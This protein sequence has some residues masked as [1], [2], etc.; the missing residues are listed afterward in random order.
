MPSRR[1]PGPSWFER[2]VPCIACGRRLNRHTETCPHCGAPQPAKRL[3][4]TIGLG[5]LLAFL[6][7]GGLYLLLAGG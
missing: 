4:G 7:L 5:G 1:R 3:G 2:D 6:L